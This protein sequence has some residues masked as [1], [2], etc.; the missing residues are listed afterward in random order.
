MAKTATAINNPVE[1]ANKAL[2]LAGFGMGE[3]ATKQAGSMPEHSVRCFVRQDGV[4]MMECSPVPYETLKVNTDSEG[5]ARSAN[6]KLTAVNVQIP[7]LF[8][9]GAVRFL[10]ARSFGI[11]LT[12]YG[13]KA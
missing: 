10:I 9:D 3:E 5:A 8:P 1:Q 7:V 11:P 12:V 4:A 2:R 13:K 6:I